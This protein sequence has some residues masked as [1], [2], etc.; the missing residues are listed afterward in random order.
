MQ[1]AL[2]TLAFVSML[3]GIEAVAFSAARSIESFVEL[4]GVWSTF[5][6]TGTVFTLEG[7]VS[8]TSKATLR[9]AKCDLI[10]HAR[11]GEQLPRLLGR[12]RNVEVVGRLVRRGGRLRFVVSRLK[13]LPSDIDHLRSETTAL[14]ERTP[15]AYYELGRWAWQ[16]AAFYE[17]QELANKA[18]ETFVRGIRLERRELEH[19]DAQGLL[20]LAARLSEYHQPDTLRQEYVHEAFHILWSASQKDG[21]PTPAK[22]AERIQETLEGADT[23][24]TDPASELR[25]EYLDDPLGVY[26]QA[27]D[28]TT[29]HK[30]H[31]IFYSEV[32]LAMIEQSADPDGRDGYET[33]AKI[34]QW[35]PERSDLVESWRQKELTYRLANVEQAARRDVVELAELF[36]AREQPDRALDAL[37]RWLANR[38]QRLRRDGPGGLLQLADEYLALLQ[39]QKRAS[40][41]LMEAYELSPIKDEIA[42]KLNKLGFVHTEGRW[43]N[44]ADVRERPPSELDTA[45]RE[46]RIELGMNGRQ[47]RQA[48]G[49]P[50]SVTRIAS[51]KQMYEIWVYGERESSRLGVHF[52]RREHET[53]AKAV[54]ISQER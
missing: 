44:K 28:A 5:A 22:L 17:D 18:I 15:E 38:E 33:A 35:L 50:S 53:E 36:R 52:L 51:R 12:S 16:R 46:G 47:V 4:K 31:R 11:K 14:R 24:L 42:E 9:F 8:S 25:R 26:E 1:S 32:R 2:R 20:D 45:V 30:L 49:V 19:D 40:E 54:A 7:R 6:S 37:T 48:I 43:I 3:F 23:A 34:G 10:F 13:Q 27:V 41:L 21:E 39:D 29:R